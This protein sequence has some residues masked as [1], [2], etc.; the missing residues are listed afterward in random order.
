MVVDFISSTGDRIAW[1][2]ILQKL[3]EESGIRFYDD[4]FDA[5]ML[6][7]WGI[8][9]LHENKEYTGMYTG[10]ELPDEIYTVLLI[11]YQK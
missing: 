4:S 10:A 7:A 3:R 11:K 1:G 2:S 5:W 9:M 6:D 8:K